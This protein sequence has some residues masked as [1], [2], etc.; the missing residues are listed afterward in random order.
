MTAVPKGMHKDLEI[1]FPILIGAIPFIQ[2]VIHHQSA[3]AMSAVPVQPSMPMPS[4][5]MP[6]VSAPSAPSSPEG[7]MPIPQHGIDIAPV[8]PCL[9]SSKSTK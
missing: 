5:V 8:A 1:T 4:Y 9:Y 2:D 3:S 6:V 7:Y